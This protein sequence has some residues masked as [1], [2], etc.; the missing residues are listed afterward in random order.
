MTSYKVCLNC[1]S[2]WGRDISHVVKAEVQ[3]G[4]SAP[5]EASQ[6]RNTVV[7]QKGFCEVG[8]IG[9]VAKNRSVIVRNL[10]TAGAGLIGVEYR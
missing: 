5:R 8:G 2:A 9:A 6:V 7:I 3:V 1:Q 10:H 4:Q